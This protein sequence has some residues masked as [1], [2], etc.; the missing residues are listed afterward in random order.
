MNIKEI[1]LDK[2]LTVNLGNFDSFKCNFGLT[3]ELDKKDNIN[4][5]I[6]HLRKE[7]NENLQ[8]EVDK[9]LTYL[10]I[11][12]VKVNINKNKRIKRR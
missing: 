10:N 1:R 2:G 7:V 11:D 3:I 6:G 8:S 12:H 4:L 5:A 9:S